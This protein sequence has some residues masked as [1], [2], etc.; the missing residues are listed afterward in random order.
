[1]RR[2]RALGYEEVANLLQIAVVQICQGKAVRE[3]LFS[4]R[5]ELAATWAMFAAATDFNYS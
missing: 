4:F 3:N 5:G 1:M 2:C